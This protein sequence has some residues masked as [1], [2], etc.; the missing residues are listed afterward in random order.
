MFTA[1][2]N[3]GAAGT[4][5]HLNNGT[6][7]TRA[8]PRTDARHITNDGGFF[9]GSGG[10][11]TW[12]GSIGGSG[13]LVK[14]GPGDLILPN[15]NTYTGGTTVNQGTINFGHVNGA[16]IVDALGSGPVALHG[17]KLRNDTGEMP[18]STTTSF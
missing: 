10:E 11:L 12:S 3:L 18:I 8:R 1:D 7:G 2:S 6:I 9:V 5:I 17:G 16:N 15:A 4:G 13:N 14:S